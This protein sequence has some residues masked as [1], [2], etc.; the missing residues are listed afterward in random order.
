M[1][2]TTTINLGGFAFTIEEAA[3]RNLKN[4]L[5]SV[6]SKIGSDIDKN[7]V[8]TDI[9]MSIAEKLKEKSGQEKKAITAKDIDELIAVMGHPD[10]FNED[11]KKEE[12]E[13]QSKRIKKK[14]FRDT[15]DVILGGV[16]SGIAVYFD[17]EPVLI[18]IVAFLLV[19]CNGIGIPVYILLW[20]IIPAAETKAQK[21]EMHGNP[22]TVSSIEQSFKDA[23]E[24]KKES[25]I[26]RVVRKIGGIVKRL[27][28][29][30]LKIV[31]FF[32]NFSII[33][34]TL[35]AIIGMTIFTA[36]LIMYSTSGYSIDNVP[37]SE[38][39][40]TMP[41][42]LFLFSL[43]LTVAIPAFLLLIADVMVA[44]KRRVVNIASVIV[45]IVV[46]MAST[47]T[48][49]AI[50]IRYAPD[51]RS[52]MG[53]V[54][55]RQ[56]VE[57]PSLGNFVNISANGKN[58]KL[59]IKKGDKFSVSANGM[60]S[61]LE[62]VSYNIDENKTLNILAEKKEENQ[63][64]LFCDPKIVRIAITIP[65]IGNIKTNKADLDMDKVVA[66]KLL[67]EAIESDLVINGSVNNLSLRAE[68]SSVNAAGNFTNLDL[69]AENSDVNMDIKSTEAKVKTKNTDSI[70]S[71]F[72]EK[73]SYEAESGS[74]LNGLELEIYNANLV[75]K[76]DSW[77]IARIENS[78]SGD[79]DEN[80]GVFYLGDANFD[81]M[82]NSPFATFTKIVKVTA[83]EYRQNQNKDNYF[84]F[85]GNKY[86]FD[87]E[88]GNSDIF[89][90]KRELLREKF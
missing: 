84:E 19:L 56:T 85:Y 36:V 34:G 35:F 9:E 60:L 53:D 45:L 44:F 29:V 63:K 40:K 59:S 55:Y 71:G 2:K 90:E 28:Q 54:Q 8:M 51:I 20:I 74:L 52:K 46:W 11:E 69:N 76:N 21:L 89:Y 18:R 26:T 14:L 3:Y 80:S 33:A 13:D 86:R 66:D 32:L 81:N 49:T 30:L 67:I 15:D 88:N 48:M 41:F 1:E 16:C 68:N 25:R 79:I 73:L 83:Y 47:A 87:I 39:T 70:F 61:D 7:E 42:Y 31:L 23:E 6:R 10:D 77:M 38:I 62:K 17:I 75:L 4:Y 12:T 37:I 57:V 78:L 24:I 82:K 58:L 64:C 22:L 50:I 43:F 27:L 65:D 5:D 72:I